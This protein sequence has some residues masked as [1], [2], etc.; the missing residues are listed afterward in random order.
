MI[1]QNIPNWWEDLTSG[2]VIEIDCLLLPST[3]NK[4]FC[5]ARMRLL[6]YAIPGT[7]KPRGWLLKHPPKLSWLY[8]LDLLLGQLTLFFIHYKCRILSKNRKKEEE[9]N[10]EHLWLGSLWLGRAF[11]WNGT[12]AL[13]GCEKIQWKID[14][15]I[16]F[17]LTSIC[18]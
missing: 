3:R 17:G 16:P 4:M 11:S 15:A 7:W 2:N 10:Y 1:C 5:C 6:P 12:G 14:L 13:E 8:A 18:W 9:N